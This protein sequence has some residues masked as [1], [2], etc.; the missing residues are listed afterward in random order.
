MRLHKALAKGRVETAMA[1][2]K[3]NGNFRKSEQRRAS[4]LLDAHFHGSTHFLVRTQVRF[5]KRY[6][7][8]GQTHNMKQQ[9]FKVGRGH[10]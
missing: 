5:I 4:L 9:S 10:L 3:P 2:K 7:Y 1:L 6:C 8:S